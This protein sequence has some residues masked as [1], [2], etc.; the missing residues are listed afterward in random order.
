MIKS[1]TLTQI[2][3]VFSL[4][5]QAVSY[6]ISLRSDFPF[7]LWFTLRPNVGYPIWEFLTVEQ[8]PLDDFNSYRFAQESLQL[9]PT[10]GGFVLYP[11]SFLLYQIFSFMSEVS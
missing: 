4:V 7:A 3:L 5:S 9:F 2:F 10:V 6:F 8:G 1:R 11:F